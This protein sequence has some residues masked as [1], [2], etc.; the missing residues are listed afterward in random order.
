MVA[1]RMA[2]VRVLVFPDSPLSSD[3]VSV[4]EGHNEDRG[5]CLHPLHD[6]NVDITYVS[7]P[8]TCTFKYADFSLARL[9]A[10]H[11]AMNQNN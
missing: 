10:L 8:I 4:P 3:E 2:L 7:L 6:H 5:F 11:S 1:L 9:F